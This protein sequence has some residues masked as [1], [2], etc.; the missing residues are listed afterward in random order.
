MS[1]LSSS[2]PVGLENEGWFDPWSLLKGLRKKAVACGAR[3]LNGEVLDFN[4][5]QPGKKDLFLSQSLASDGRR[6]RGVKVCLLEA[7]EDL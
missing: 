1:L 3:F 4:V 6:A 7:Q 2:S 5:L